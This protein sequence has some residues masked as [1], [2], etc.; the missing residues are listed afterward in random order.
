M[1]NVRLWWNFQSAGW[2]TA[3]PVLHNSNKTT[4]VIIRINV[5]LRRVRVSIVAVKEQEAL[6]ILSMYMYP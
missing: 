2:I 3:S 6:H 1:Y 4:I 5:I